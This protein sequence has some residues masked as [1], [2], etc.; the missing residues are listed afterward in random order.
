VHLHR[1]IVGQQRAALRANGV[2]GDVGLQPAE[3]RLGMGG[4]TEVFVGLPVGG[5]A[6]LQFA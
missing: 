6:A 2:G 5:Q 3:Q 4:A 1:A